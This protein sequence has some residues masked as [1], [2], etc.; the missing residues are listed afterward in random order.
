M[1]LIREFRK[2]NDAVK[3]RHEKLLSAFMSKTHHWTLREAHLRLKGLMH[4][5]PQE[6]AL[7]GWAPHSSFL[8]PD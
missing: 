8:N 4:E 7:R 1:G 5:P 3:K 2:D 6:G